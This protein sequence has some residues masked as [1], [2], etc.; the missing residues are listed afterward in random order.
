MVGKYVFFHFLN[1][2]HS[3]EKTFAA[4]S[5]YEIIFV[6]NLPSKILY[7]HVTTVRN[8]LGP[9]VTQLIW[10]NSPK[11]EKKKEI[12]ILLIFNLM[13]KKIKQF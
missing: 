1:F 2:P 9:F 5:L 3:L 7:R 6:N 10:Q 11:K 8:L 4:G 13:K 12:I